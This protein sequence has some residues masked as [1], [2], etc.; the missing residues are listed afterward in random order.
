MII[1]IKI[2]ITN[3]IKIKIINQRIILISF[4]FNLSTINSAV[5]ISSQLS[6]FLLL[7]K[8]MLLLLFDF[9]ALLNDDFESDINEFLLVMFLFIFSSANFLFSLEI[10]FTFGSILY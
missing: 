3:I 9:V 7:F 1:L 10:K 6:F 2:Y 5:N 4:I 8:T